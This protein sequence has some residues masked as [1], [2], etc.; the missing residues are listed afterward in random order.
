[1]VLYILI[2]GIIIFL[3]VACWQPKIRFYKDFVKITG[4]S[5]M[6]I[7]RTE[8]VSVTEK[9]APLPAMCRSGAL[10]LYF[11]G[12]NKGYF[13]VWEDSE[14]YNL[15]NNDICKL[16]IQTRKPPFIV[17]TLT[18]NLQIFINFRNKKIMEKYYSE[19]LKYGKTED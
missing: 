8:I 1:M 19:F 6:K 13:T 12:I 2:G 10:G 4:I 14:I 3:I 17:I 7:K 15:K 5:G 11:F 16:Y 18:N 9:D